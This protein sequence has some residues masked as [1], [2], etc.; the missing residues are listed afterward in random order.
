MAFFLKNKIMIRTFLI[1]LIA[2]VSGCSQS[3]QT[4]N[5]LTQKEIKYAKGFT[6]GSGNG[7]KVIEVTNPWQPTSMLQT[8]VLVPKSDPLPDSLPK[9]TIVRTPLENL[10]VYTGVDAGILDFLGVANNISGVCESEYITIPSVVKGIESGKIIDLGQSTMPSI[11]KIISLK[12]EGL[13]VSPYQNTGYGAVE[14][15]AV[16]I[17]E[18][19]AY[20]ENTPLGQSEWIKF[21]AA[22]VNKENLADSLFSDIESKYNA[23][24]AIVSAVQTKPTLLP[25][26]KFGQAWH[27]AAGESFMAAIYADAGGAYPWSETTGQGSLSLSFEEVYVKAKKADYWFVTYNNRIKDMDYNDLKSEYE[28]YEK[29]D[30]FKNKKI[31]G[32]NTATSPIFETSI[33]TPY[34]LLSDYIKVLHPNL[35]PNYTLTYFK[36]L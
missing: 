7:Y 12:P 29:F 2:I 34:L 25:G 22:F 32:C 19:A 35:L 10:V 36:P 31:Y 28:N 33:F 15:L 5:T 23:T 30:A 1:L 11:E 13:I 18:C 17:I 14:K 4:D 24:K 9:G 26:K 8:Y 27:V 16:P 20:M 3:S 21:I 6:I